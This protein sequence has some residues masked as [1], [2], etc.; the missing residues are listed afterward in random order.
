MHLRLKLTFSV[1]E[2][3]SFEVKNYLLTVKIFKFSSKQLMF[4]IAL[5]KK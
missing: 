3:K 4:F 2:R 1:F 5:Y